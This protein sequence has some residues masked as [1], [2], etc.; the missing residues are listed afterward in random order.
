[1]T[2]TDIFK[3]HQTQRQKTLFT[4]TPSCCTR[5]HK[6][7]QLKAQKHK[8]AHK[9]QR[10]LESHDTAQRESLLH[11]YQATPPATALPH[12]RY[13]TTLPNTPVEMLQ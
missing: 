8:I 5:K 7:L 10:P 11:K 4:Q 2:P 9:R 3:V 1:M 13:T 6:A 12:N